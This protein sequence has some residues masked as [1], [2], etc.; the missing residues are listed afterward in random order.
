MRGSRESL[1]GGRERLARSRAC[2]AVFVLLIGSAAALALPAP[3]IAAAPCWRQ[4]IADWSKDGRIDGT[5]AVTCYRAAVKQLPEDLRAY[6]SA[7]DDI[8]RAL[9]ERRTSR[10]R[11]QALGAAP[12][13]AV[14][15]GT[16]GRSGLAVLLPSLAGMVGAVAVVLWLL[17]VRRRRL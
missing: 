3:G 1:T 9:L 17:R 4:V 10:D 14:S 8:D 12:P 6:S 2:V 5:Y 16:A 13:A 11:V 15:T 7:P